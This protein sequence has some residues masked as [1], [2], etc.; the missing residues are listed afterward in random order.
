MADSLHAG[1]DVFAALGRYTQAVV[2][3]A[4]EAVNAEREAVY[5]A[6][7]E[8]ARNHPSWQGVA[9]HIEIWDTDGGYEFGVRH[10]DHVDAAI[11]AEY[12][13][14]GTPPAPILRDTQKYAERGHAA[15]DWSFADLLGTSNPYDH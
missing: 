1:A 3:A 10:P 11:K 9:D 8:S 6:V 2:D 13:D 7:M 15:A 5:Q 4:H 14:K 12:G